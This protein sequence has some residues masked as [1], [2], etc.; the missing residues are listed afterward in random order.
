[1]PM[2][3]IEQTTAS[4]VYLTYSQT[5]RM[6]RKTHAHLRTPE[7]TWTPTPTPTPTPQQTAVV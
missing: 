2:Q 1:M 7:H 6:P 5:P 4:H 3:D